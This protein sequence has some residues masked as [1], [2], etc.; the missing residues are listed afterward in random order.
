VDALEMNSYL[1]LLSA[2]DD[3]Q[4]VKIATLFHATPPPSRA[5]RYVLHVSALDDARRLGEVI[6]Y[7]CRRSEANGRVARVDFVGHSKLFGNPDTFGL[8]AGNKG[9]LVLGQRGKSMPVG[10]DLLRAVAR[11]GTED[12]VVRLILC[13]GRRFQIGVL[14]RFRDVVRRSCPRATLLVTR[15]GA[16]ANEEHFGGGGFFA[17]HLLEAMNEK[18]D[19]IPVR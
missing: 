13:A 15:E 9:E 4:F 8:R 14:R 17:T 19:L 12:L 18:G 11:Y 2:E 16:N 7:R 10:E 1:T 5:N 3:P 6:D